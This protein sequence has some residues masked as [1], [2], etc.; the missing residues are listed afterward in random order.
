M[1]RAQRPADGRQIR[2]LGP[3]MLDVA[4]QR[5][6]PPVALE[7]HW[8]DGRNDGCAGFRRRLRERKL[9]HERLPATAGKRERDARDDRRRTEM[10]EHVRQVADDDR[11]AGRDLELARERDGR[12]GVGV[13]ASSANS[14]LN[15]TPI[16]SASCAVSA[17]TGSRAA[18]LKPS[19]SAHSN[20]A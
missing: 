13:Q 15:G 5:D 7:R 1:Q 3:A 2:R 14:T 4:P 19:M 8:L 6:E 20:S 18:S 10:D 12:L 9:P 17:N 16:A 11:V